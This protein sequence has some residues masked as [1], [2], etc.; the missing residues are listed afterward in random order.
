MQWSAVG[1]PPE[2]L[3]HK[4][5]L[6]EGTANSREYFSVTI[7]QVGKSLQTSI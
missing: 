3:V 5:D 2:R 4:I 1:S 6:A 7:D